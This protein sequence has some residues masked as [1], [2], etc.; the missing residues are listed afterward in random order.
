MDRR[1]LLIHRPKVARR[2]IYGQRLLAADR[3][4]NILDH[5]DVPGNALRSFISEILE[6]SEDLP[7]RDKE[8]P[9]Q[10]PD[11]QDLQEL[12]PIGEF[13]RMVHM[14]INPRIIRELWSNTWM[15]GTFKQ[16]IEI[17]LMRFTAARL[18]FPCLQVVGQRHF[19]LLVF[20]VRTT[21]SLHTEG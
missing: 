10:E 1:R 8:A 20:V 7:N 14:K 11:V 9:S 2:P 6:I 16:G 3:Q 4:L 15:Q 12:H 21:H 18:S 13:A 19:Q 5:D 17:S